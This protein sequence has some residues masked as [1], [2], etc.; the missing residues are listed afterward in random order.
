MKFL[1]KIGK[2][3]FCFLAAFS[4]KNE[5]KD[6][7]QFW[8]C[9]PKWTSRNKNPNIYRIRIWICGFLTGHELSKTEWGY[10]GGNF[11]DRHCRW[12]DKVIRVPKCEDDVPHKAIDR[13]AK[14]LGFYE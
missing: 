2:L 10:G 5:D 11:V 8:Y 7:I 3:I 4:K 13:M 9:W 6:Y 1:H 12:R 14:R